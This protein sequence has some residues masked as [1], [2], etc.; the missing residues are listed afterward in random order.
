ML[1]KVQKEE[2]LY[3]F[4]RY[5]N[6]NYFQFC[7]E[8]DLVTLQDWFNANK[9]TLSIKKAVIMLF[10]NKISRTSPRIQTGGEY[11]PV[12]TSANFFGVWMDNQLN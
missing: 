1:Q 4:Q 10:E 12:V 11:L 3:I 7:M 6:K 2:Q 8:S 9:L 5:V